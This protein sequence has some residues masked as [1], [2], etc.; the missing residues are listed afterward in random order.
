[1]VKKYITLSLDDERISYI[2]KV[3]GNRTCKR[4][5]ELLTTEELTETEI[6][7]RLKIPLTTVHY[8]IEQLLKAGL[9]YKSKFLWSVRGKKVP[10][11]QV[12]NKY[13]VI[14]PK[15]N[16]LANHIKKGGITL[17]ISIAI[18][19]LLWLF[20][21]QRLAMLKGEERGLLMENPELVAETTKMNLNPQNLSSFLKDFVINIPT[22]GWFLIGSLIAIFIYFILNIKNK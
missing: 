10:F 3:I 21:H 7:E 5:I 4:I 13:I 15:T 9:I 12:A 17:L 20:S 1:M 8:N 2:S 6:S 16:E 18:T 19:A 14:T 22:W 11:Y